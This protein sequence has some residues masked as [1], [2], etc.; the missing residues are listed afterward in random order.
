MAVVD[1]AKL[2][3]RVAEAS[4]R[5]LDGIGDRPVRASD[6]VA[7]VRERL[8]GALP[9]G[10]E[11]PAEVL[12]RL[13]ALAPTATVASTGPRYFGFV[14]GGSLPAALAA[15]LLTVA[16]DQN[17]AMAALS[18]LAAAVEQ[19][20]AG[21]LVD[22]LGLP[23]SASVGFVTGGQSANTTCLTVARHHA[24]ARCGW[25]VEARGL[26][27]APTVHTVVGRQRHAT[28]D[29]ALRALG[30]GAPGAEVETDSEGRMRPEALA[31]VLRAARGPVIVCAQAGNVNSGAFDPF[32][33]IV[34]LA[35][36][37]QA[38][39]HVDGAFGMWAQA[40]P[41]RRHLTA[42]VA[43]ADSWA[44]DGHKWLNVPY[45]CGYAITAHPDSHR[46]AFA[47]TAAYYVKGGPDEPR[48]GGDWV[49]EASRRARGIATWAA[50][51]S[52]GR[53]GVADLVERCCAHA[54]H[55]ATL[56]AAEPG[57]AVLNEVELNQVL[58]RFDDS[59]EHTRA[60]IAAIQQ[61]GTCWAGG[62]V[63]HGR[64]VLRWSVSNWSTTTGDIVRSAEAVLAAHRRL[65][66]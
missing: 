28:V 16:L 25:D 19:I 66:G 30:L 65:R 44:V 2:L 48:D 58:V 51:R 62:S 63:W 52:L 47:S 20:A 5:Y 64:A 39:L 3:A 60:V 59:D 42:G 12:E 29:V 45:D 37:H 26:Q 27:G 17:A 11:D 46:A 56:V 4:A 8:G 10:G 54:A 35:R 21:W 55:F 40:C 34:E 24:L 41:S 31:E 57:V 38:W 1:L 50:L 6:G 9:T 61:E 18:P 13:I 15:E 33:A 32:P 14:V 53:T 22:V 43:G 7:V 36:G 23:A 49:P